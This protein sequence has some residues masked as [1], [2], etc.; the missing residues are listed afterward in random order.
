MTPCLPFQLHVNGSKSL[1]QCYL[2]FYIYEVLLE[3]SQ[4]IIVVTASVEDERGSQGHTPASLLHQ[5]VMQHCA[6]NTHCFYPS[7]FSTSCFVL[8]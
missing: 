2:L 4:T 5:S 1:L 6:V 8:S 7:A 3:S